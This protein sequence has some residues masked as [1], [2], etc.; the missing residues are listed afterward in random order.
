LK[1]CPLTYAI[2]TGRAARWGM[3]AAERAIVTTVPIAAADKNSRLFIMRSY[4]Y[5]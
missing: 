3:T 1:K 4:E 2:T 5:P